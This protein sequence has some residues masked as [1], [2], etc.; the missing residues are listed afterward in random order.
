M[1]LHVPKA[2]GFQSMLKDG[3]RF[4]S[5]VD[6]VALKNIDACKELAETTKSAYGPNGMNKM[7]INHIEKLFVTN[8]AATMMREVEVQHPAAK[9]VLMASDMQE[10]EVGDGTN[11]VLIFAGQLLQ[12]AGDL[13]N[14][15]LSPVEIIDGYNLALTRV[16][17]ILPIKD[18]HNRDLVKKALKSCFSSKQLGNE[19]FLSELVGDACMRTLKDNQS[20]NVDNVR[21]CKILGCGIQSSTVMQGMVL[22]REV[23]GTVWKAQKPKI[24]LYSCPLDIST[25]ET[26]GTVLIKNA[27][28]LKSFSRGEEELLEKQVKAICDSGVKVV[29]CGGKVGEM[30]LHFLNKYEIMAVRVL[31]KFDLRRVAKTVNGTVLAKIVP[32]TAEEMGYC[33]TVYVDEVGDV[34][35][36]LFK[37]DKEEGAISTVVVRGSTDNIMDDI[38][39]SI[40]DGVNNFKGLTKEGRLLPGAGAT[41]MELAKQLSSISETYPGLEQYAIKKFAE[42]FEVIP[43]TLAEN[44]GRKST[45]ILSQLYALHEE[46]KSTYGFNIEEDSDTVDVNEKGIYDLYLTKYWGIT[47]ATK[48]AISVLYVDKI[49]MAKPAGGPKPKE[50]KDWDNDD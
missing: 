33:D 28:E 30:A 43:K 31:S 47:Y 9:L 10:K 25:T 18:L 39:R 22:K 4:Y 45:E 40:D 3:A 21:V 15:G 23:E 17:E 1:A 6:E 34:P 27:E 11:F 13:L 42:A 7:V 12:N 24:A 2:P 26:K 19:D 35:V 16:Q 36:I 41:E 8:D 44:S 38:E 14:M 5:G 37:Q 46:G 32:P 20:F 49:I 50:N 29:I 48:A